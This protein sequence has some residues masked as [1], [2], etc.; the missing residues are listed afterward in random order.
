MY[1]QKPVQKASKENDPITQGDQEGAKQK[2]QFMISFIFNK[3]VKAC[4]IRAIISS[5]R[6]LLSNHLAMDTDLDPEPMTYMIIGSQRG[7]RK[8]Q[9]MTHKSALNRSYYLDQPSQAL[10]IQE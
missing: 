3:T 1:I 7:V 10:K 4:N 9:E 6:C 8:I 2:V 5:I